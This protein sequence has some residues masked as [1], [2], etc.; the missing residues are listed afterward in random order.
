MFGTH[1]AKCGERWDAQG[2]WLRAGGRCADKLG[3]HDY[4]LAMRLAVRM[5]RL[6]AISGVAII[7]DVVL[8][9]MARPCHSAEAQ[10]NGATPCAAWHAR[11][12]CSRRV[13]R[14]DM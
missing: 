3:F 5:P 11:C 10:T 13:S 8:N 12:S 14:E 7:A 6:P 2:A 9:H 4:V 1:D